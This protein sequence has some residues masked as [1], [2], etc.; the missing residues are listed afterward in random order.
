MRKNKFPGKFIVSDGLDGSGQS[1]KAAR[2][3]D[4]LNDPKQKLRFGHTGV[5]LTKEPTSG[6]IGGLIRGQLNHDWQSSPECLQL[7]FAA[8]RAWHLEKEIIPLLEKGIIVV[9]D[10]YF[11][12]SLAY[13]AVGIKDANWLFQINSNF[14]LPDI[15]FFLRV[16]PKICLERIQKNRH[17]ITLFEQEQILEKVRGN[18]KRL[19]PK[20][21]NIYVIPGERPADKIAKDIIGIVGKKLG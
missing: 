2:L 8:D 18:Y 7:L 16:S 13:G 19:V 11:F 17:G 6:L 10:R 1:T 4:C 21:K 15:T 5:H 3:I 12:S 14:L 9:C 20:F